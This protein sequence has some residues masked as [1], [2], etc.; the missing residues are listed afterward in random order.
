MP[1]APA[2]EDTKA[3]ASFSHSSNFLLHHHQQHHSQPHVAVFASQHPSSFDAA[4]IRA[5]AHLTCVHA[6][7]D[8]LGGA[9]RIHVLDRLRH[10]HGRAVA[11]ADAGARAT[12]KV[13]ALVSSASHHPLELQLIHDNLS[14]FAQELVAI[15]NGD[16]VA[17][18]SP[19][20]RHTWPQCRPS[21][22]S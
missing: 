2:M 9:G 14:G 11:V 17:S 8:E 21:S 22:A 19:W 18:T 10:R 15:T 4:P 3:T 5:F 12:L 7:L 16:V 13:T 6:V 1:F 20:G